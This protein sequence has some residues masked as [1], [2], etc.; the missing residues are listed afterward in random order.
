MINSKIE[1]PITSIIITLAEYMV[2]SIVCICSSSPHIARKISICY[3]A[4]AHTEG[5]VT[6][7]DEHHEC[8]S[9]RTYLHLVS[10]FKCLFPVGSTISAKSIYCSGEITI[11]RSKAISGSGNIH[12]LRR[13]RECD[14]RHTNIAVLTIQQRICHCVCC[15]LCRLKTSDI[16]QIIINHGSGNIEYHYDI[17]RG[18]FLYR[19]FRASDCQRYIICAISVIGG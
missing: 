11:I 10:Q 8:G 14:Q 6:V 13:C 5:R 19:F 7:C 1:V 9:V 16:P 12:L 18:G 2:V 17:C 4:T 3:I 15:I